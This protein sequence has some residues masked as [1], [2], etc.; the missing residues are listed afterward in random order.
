MRERVQELGGVLEI[1]SANG[2]TTVKAI[3][4]LAGNNV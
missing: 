1:L 2:G 4:P 3:I